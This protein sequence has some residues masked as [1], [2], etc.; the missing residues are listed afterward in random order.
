MKDL[1]EDWDMKR[2][3]LAALAALALSACS[4]AVKDCAPAPAAETLQPAPAPT[5]FL[6]Y[7]L[8]EGVTPEAFE[9]WVVE[10]DYPAMRALER[11]QSFR[12]YRAERLLIGEGAPG[13][14]YIEAFV[15]PDMDGF[16]A[17][18]MGSETVQSIMG[19]FM[20][21]AEAPQF[22]VVSEVK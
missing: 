19:Q 7:S 4:G 21:F 22:I 14:A 1:K 18:D 20:G 13:V 15:I 16:I 17:E 8:K 6:L 3:F 5:L 10:T 12:T 2:L 11:V 9:Q